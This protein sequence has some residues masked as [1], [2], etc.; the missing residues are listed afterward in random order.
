M[1]GEKP[2][3]EALESGRVVL[4]RGRRG[5]SREAELF[6]GGI[7]II[8]GAFVYPY[9]QAISDRLYPGCIFHRL[10]GLPC[11]LCG[12][13]RSLVATAHGRLADAFRLHLLGPPLFAA[14]AVGAMFLGV[15]LAIGRH[16]LPRPGRRGRKLLAWGA[17]GLLVAAWVAR[18]IFF[19]VNV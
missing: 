6:A 9:V 15:E 18:L 3:V 5:I 7:L 19:G 11:L 2:D 14:I 8:A 1:A 16:L 17:L 4:R 12:M 13:T 10:T